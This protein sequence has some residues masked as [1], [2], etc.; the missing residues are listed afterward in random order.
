MCQ[1]GLAA[2]PELYKC[3]K[4][5]IDPTN[6]ITEIVAYNK[7]IAL[8]DRLEQDKQ[9]NILNLKTADPVADVQPP[10]TV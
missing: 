1:P 10:V 2:G 6:R 5:I 9:D 4:A 7:A 3:L 8:L